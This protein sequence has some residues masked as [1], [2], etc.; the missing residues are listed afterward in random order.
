MRAT[1]KLPKSTY[2]RETAFAS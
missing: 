2:E 1:K